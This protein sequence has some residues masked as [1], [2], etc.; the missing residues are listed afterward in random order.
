MLME[1]AW[2]YM[3]GPR[4]NVIDMQRIRRKLDHGF[5]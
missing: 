5:A 4:G 1:P 3:F 2:Q